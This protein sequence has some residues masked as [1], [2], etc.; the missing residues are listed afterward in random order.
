MAKGKFNGMGGMPNMNNMLKQ[1]QKMQQEMQ[2]QQEEL[3]NSTVEATA[4]GGA[5]TV[6]MSGAHKLTSVKIKPEACDP[7]DVE[8]LEDLIITAVNDAI[9]QINQIS[10]KNIEKVTGGFNIPGLF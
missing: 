4:G 6:T 1:A 2:K 10:A 9:S 8:M 5:I 3:E 7:D